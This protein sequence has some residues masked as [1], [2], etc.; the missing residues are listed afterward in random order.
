MSQLHL[1]AI[2]VVLSARLF[3]KM[4]H[5][6]DL[7]GNLKAGLGKFLG[8]TLKFLVTIFV[9]YAE[10]SKSSDR[11]SS[12]TTFSGEQGN[13]TFRTREDRQKLERLEETRSRDAHDQAQ[14]VYR[15]Q[16][17]INRQKD[18]HNAQ[19]EEIRRQQEQLEHTAKIQR[20]RLE[21][22]MTEIWYR[23]RR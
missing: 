16:Q 15:Q 1:A 6:S 2:L 20:Q 14:L 22:M 5:R 3:K 4:N 13:Q 8:G 19:M 18:F 11:T 10:V 7:F 21:G 9:F 17:E 23:D 12:E